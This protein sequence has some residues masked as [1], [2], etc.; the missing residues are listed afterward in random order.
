MPSSSGTQKLI[1]ARGKLAVGIVQ[2]SQIFSEKSSCSG[3][4]SCLYTSRLWS[5]RLSVRTPG[6]QPGKRGS[7]PLGTASVYFPFKIKYLNAELNVARKCAARLTVLEVT[8]ALMH[9]KSVRC[10]RFRVHRT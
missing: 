9:G 5:L 2:F 3:G 4:F 1:T 10:W 7:I 8:M 6:F